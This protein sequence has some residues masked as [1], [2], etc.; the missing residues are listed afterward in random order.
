MVREVK[1][2]KVLAQETQ[3]VSELILWPICILLPLG[4]TKPENTN[5]SFNSLVSSYPPHKG[6]GHPSVWLTERAT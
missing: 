1:D 5:T 6:E 3:K 4:F 2:R